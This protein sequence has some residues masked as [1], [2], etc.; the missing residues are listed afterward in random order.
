[1]RAGQGQGGLRVLAARASGCPIVWVLA[2]PA[3]DIPGATDIRSEAEARQEGLSAAD[4]IVACAL[5]LLCI[6]VVMVNSSLMTVDPERS[7]SWRSVL[8]SDSARYMGLAVV[9]M[10]VCRALPI[11]RW[12]GSPRI[13]RWTPLLL[14]M[15]IGVLGLVYLPSVGHSVN[16][17]HRWVMI[18]GTETTFQPSEIAKWA[19]PIFLVWLCVRSAHRLH[20]FW[21]GLVPALIPLGIVSAM[22]TLEDLGTGVLIAAAGS[23]VLLAGGARLK[24]FLWFAP[25]GAAGVVAAVAVQPYR[26]ERVRTFLDPFQDPQGS[27]YH[28]VQ[29]LVSVANGQGT[30]RGLGFG[31]QK[32]GY[33]PEDHTDFLF[34]VIAEE[35]GLAGVIV[36]VSLYAVMLLAGLSVMRGQK[37]PAAKLLCVGILSTI[38]LQ[39]LM[40][41][42]VVTAMVPT[43]GIALP[44]LS[45]GGTGWI[46]TAACLGLLA[47]LG[48]GRRV[49]VI[50]ST[51]LGL[52]SMLE[53][54]PRSATPQ[55]AQLAP[56]RPAQANA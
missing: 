28:V 41:M 21:A 4:V 20:R 46:A 24:H 44:L 12:L 23:L 37:S 36:V 45:S 49:R 42:M 50:E 9:A 32:F 22:V 54:K 40:N 11:A 35:L 7:I 15:S 10:L 6:G 56:R 18:P 26:L 38:G 14:P 16:G 1:M 52:D 5:A 25:I 19:L 31:L 33:L 13:F 47:S 39:A 55:R 17:S 48:T 2:N 8:G 3:N 27:G 34:A 30:G 51:P 53:T 29:S 43:K